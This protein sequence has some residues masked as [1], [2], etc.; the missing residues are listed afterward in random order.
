MKK[1]VITASLVLSAMASFGGGYQL[2]LQGLR[3]MAM[4]GTGAAWPWDASTIFYNPGG[5]SRLHGVQ[6]YV[7]T[8]V[9]VPSTSYGNRGTSGITSANENTVS[10][11]F[12]P[13][14]LYIGGPVHEDARVGVGLGVYTPF[15][16]GVK[17]ND[18]WLG[19]YIV[20]SV[21]LKTVF[22]QPTLSFRITEGLSIGAGLVIGAGSVDYTRAL[23]VH[24]QQ[25]PGLDDG[26]AHLHGS[27]T[28]VGFN[29]GISRRISENVYLGLTYRS[30]VN[31]DVSGGTAKFKV[32]TSLR[33]SFPNTT[34]DARLPM[35]EVLTLG[36]GWRIND[37]TLQL[38]CNYTGWSAY[39]SLRFDFK[40]T[41]SSLTNIR[42]PRKYRNTFT[43]RFGMAYKVSR[44]VGLMGG[45]A[46]DPTPVTNDYVSPDLPDADR[47]IL[48][49]GITVK[50]LPGLTL[51][52][53]FE[54]ANG[55]KRDGDYVY[56][57]FSGVYKTNAAIPAFGLYY[58]F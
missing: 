14:N 29:V 15:G 44:V 52:A 54:A 25:G 55:V 46:Y 3:Q 7:S 30:Q 23:P 28:G 20:Q 42:A 26:Q 37:V 58:I 47:I 10:Q 35:P 32:P 12:M 50:P 19:R 40:Q 5:L 45:V 16:S 27:A 21:D 2:N 24:G 43:P 22:F 8:G 33:D 39:D 6:A 48:S 9:I 17:W 1:H 4:G 49:C 38:D 31:M 18:N 41:T 57:G 53:S 51:M 13:F 56:G 11:S 36:L 34:F